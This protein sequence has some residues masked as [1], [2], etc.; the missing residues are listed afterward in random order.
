MGER[1]DGDSKMKPLL[2]GMNNPLSLTPGHELGDRTLLP[3]LICTSEPNGI[4][5]KSSA[6]QCD[7]IAKS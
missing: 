4:R 5:E 7:R 2:I 6:L 1:L 3:N